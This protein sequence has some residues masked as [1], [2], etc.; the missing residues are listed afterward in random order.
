VVLEYYENGGGALAQLRWGSPSTA[1]T[2]IPSTQLYPLGNRAPVFTSAVLAAPNPALVGQNVEF[3]AAA[4][5]A[6]GD[7]LTMHWNFG[8]GTQ[9]TGSSTSHAYQTAGAYTVTVMVSDGRGETATSSV[10]ITV[11]NDDGGGL[12]PSGL[13]INFQPAIAV[14]GSVTAGIETSALRHAIEMRPILR[15][16]AT[17]L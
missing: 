15:T 17:I 13:R 11:V 16:S 14:T 10:A 6:D 12:P 4:S 9:G 1:K 3:V 5:D 2:I 8:D 7:V